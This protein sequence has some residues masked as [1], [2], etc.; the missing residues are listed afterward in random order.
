MVRQPDVVSSGRDRMRVPRLTQ[1]PPM[2]N[3]K[4]FGAEGLGMVKMD[5]MFADQRRTKLA[6]HV[7][8]FEGE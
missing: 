3:S 1:T 6:T 4:T 5:G 8:I 7:L 2:S